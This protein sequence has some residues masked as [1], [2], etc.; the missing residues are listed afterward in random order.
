MSFW[1]TSRTAWIKDTIQ[2]LAQ[3]V[4]G[5]EH[6]VECIHQT[7][8]GR[9]LEVDQVVCWHTFLGAILE[10]ASLPVLTTM[11]SYLGHFLFLCF[12]YSLL[13]LCRHTT[14]YTTRTDANRVC[15]LEFGGIRFCF[16]CV[17]ANC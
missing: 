8:R 3:G 4:A 11:L 2:G 12:A 5:N 6:G 17:E 13:S 9:Q 1:G 15:S 7:M 16:V 14:I 10:L